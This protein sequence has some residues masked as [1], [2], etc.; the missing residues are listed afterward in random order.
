METVH[1][2]KGGIGQDLTFH[3]LG[4]HFDKKESIYKYD[5]KEWIKINDG[6]LIND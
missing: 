3:I 6:Y 5:N 1:K 2:F 4:D